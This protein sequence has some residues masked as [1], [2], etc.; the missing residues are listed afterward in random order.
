MKIF[1]SLPMKQPCCSSR[2][3]VTGWSQEKKKTKTILLK[4]DSGQ[5]CSQSHEV[6]GG[7]IY[8]KRNISVQVW[9]TFSYQ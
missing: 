3:N 8:D 1:H 2:S 4:V 7:Y 6:T 9:S 5:T